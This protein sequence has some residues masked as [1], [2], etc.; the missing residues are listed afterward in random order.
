M[1]ADEVGQ[2][3]HSKATRGIALTPP[4]RTQLDEWYRQQDAAESKS[5]ARRDTGS[6]VAALRSQVAEA[7][8]QM[9]AVASEIQNLVGA[10]EA[11]RREVAALE[12]RV[13]SPYPG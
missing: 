11:L 13:A 9:Q 3:L 5:M 2:E 8:S 1:I 10:N 7:L 12:E 4:E 6:T